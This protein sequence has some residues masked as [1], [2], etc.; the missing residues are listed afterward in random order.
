M[1]C[2]LSFLTDVD[3]PY[4][5]NYV[6]ANNYN[7]ILYIPGFTLKSMRGP[8]GNSNSGVYVVCAEG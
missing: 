4:K 1:I 6:V 3:S 8:V 2:A 5:Y 7:C